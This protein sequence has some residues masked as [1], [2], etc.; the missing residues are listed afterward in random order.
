VLGAK[1]HFLTVMIMAVTMAVVAV[2]RQRVDGINLQESHIEMRKVIREVLRMYGTLK[3]W[4]NRL[5]LQNTKEVVMAWSRI[6][7]DIYHLRYKYQVGYM[8]NCKHKNPRKV[9]HGKFYWD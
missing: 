3:L 6:F 2:E 9:T 5:L 4:H 8:P 1:S 7:T